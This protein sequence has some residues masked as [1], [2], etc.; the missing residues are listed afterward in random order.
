ML[1]LP[2]SLSRIF[3]LLSQEDCCSGDENW[4]LKLGGDGILQKENGFG[5]ANEFSS[6]C[7]LLQQISS[8]LL[9]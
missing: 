6:Q 2:P 8:D 4:T 9:G 3:Q 7:T 1:T 5:M